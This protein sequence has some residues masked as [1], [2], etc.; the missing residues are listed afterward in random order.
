MDMVFSGR[1]AT[2]GGAASRSAS[3]DAAIAVAG[4]DALYVFYNHY[5]G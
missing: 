2:G 4:D 3:S 5:S 1:A